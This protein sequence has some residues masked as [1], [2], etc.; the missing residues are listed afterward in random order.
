MTFVNTGFEDTEVFWF[1]IDSSSLLESSTVALALLLTGRGGRQQQNSTTFSQKSV[2]RHSA[3]LPQHVFALLRE[4]A[5]KAQQL[6]VSNPDWD[7]LLRTLHSI[8][9][10]L[11]CRLSQDKRK[12]NGL[13]AKLN[14]HWSLNP[15]PPPPHIETSTALPLTNLKIKCSRLI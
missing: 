13:F 15:P 10:F 7:F 8:S 14:G 12:Q 1:L 3:I 6:T 4:P 5:S 2:G 9:G 11:S